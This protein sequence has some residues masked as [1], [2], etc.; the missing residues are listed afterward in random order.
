[1]TLGRNYETAAVEYGHGRNL[2]GIEYGGSGYITS[3]GNDAMSTPFA[4]MHRDSVDD[5]KD[6][7][8][9]YALR[10]FKVI[11]HKQRYQVF[12]P[13]SLDESL[14]EN[15]VV[16]FLLGHD[17]SRCAATT[18]DHLTLHADKHG[19]AFRLR[20]PPTS[21]GQ[22]IKAGVSSNRLCAMSAGVIFGKSEMKVIEGVEI[23]FIKTAEISE[24]SLVQSGACKPAF[25]H[26]RSYDGQSLEQDCRQGAV[27]SDGAYVEMMKAWRKLADV[28]H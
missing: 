12:L 21:L 7:L 8:Q 25:A 2:G 13:G 11:D 5:G 10:W 1:M 16:G 26:L 6:V 28:L 14:A 27:M 17:E 18:K 4:H 20:I 24:I 9:G 3:V 22:E 23:H 15:K 19:L